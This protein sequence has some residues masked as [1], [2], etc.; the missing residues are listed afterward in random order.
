MN[1]HFS[2]PLSLAHIYRFVAVCVGHARHSQW[3]SQP[4]LAITLIVLFTVTMPPFAVAL[5]WMTQLFSTKTKVLLSFL[6]VGLLILVCVAPR[7]GNPAII[8]SAED[9]ALTEAIGYSRD[10]HT[11]EKLKSQLSSARD[12]KWHDIVWQLNKLQPQNRVWE[13]A[14]LSY[15]LEEELRSR[16][17]RYFGPFVQIDSVRIEGTIRPSESSSY[18]HPKGS[19]ILYFSFSKPQSGRIELT[20]RLISTISALR[21][22]DKFDAIGT[23]SFSLINLSDI[24]AAQIR[25]LMKG[26]IPLSVVKEQDWKNGAIAERASLLVSKGML[27]FATQFQD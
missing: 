12:S 9:K 26:D 11:I 18:S 14:L 17:I 16:A 21:E 25:T 22:S 15:E 6:P 27:T 4:R 2:H 8:V 20:K 7:P 1:S 19:W 24:H 5:I 13:E 10:A 3:V 23:L